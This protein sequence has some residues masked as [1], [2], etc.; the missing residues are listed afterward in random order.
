LGREPSTYRLGKRGRIA[1]SVMQ[2]KPLVSVICLCYNHASYVIEALKSVKAQTYPAIEMIVVDDASTDGSLEIIQEYLKDKQDIPF[3]KLKQNIGNCAAFNQ[4]FQLAQGKYIIDFATDDILVPHRIATQ[5]A[6]FEQLSVQ[7]AVV[8][9]DAALIDEQGAII[10]TYYARTSDGKLKSA[11]PTGEVYQELLKKAFICS[12][13]MMMR[14]AVLA[15]LGGYD[16][17]LSYEDYDFWIRSGR[18]YLY[19]FQDQILTQKRILTD[20]HR[21]SFYK[22]KQNP[23]L[24]STLKI[25]QKAFAQNKSTAENL[26]LAVSV[27]YHL[28]QAL[29]MELFDLALQ[30]AQLL[31]KLDKL[32][33]KDRLS[34]QLAKWRIGLYDLYQWYLQLK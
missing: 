29:F 11:V 14:Q 22:R 30:Y 7:Y 28:R 4:A 31:Q 1:H 13:T 10:R 33:W 12:P 19:H 6:I 23:H 2:S 26:A 15:E 24:V 32:N 25:C 27:R 34:I 21:M 8:F 5:V 9:S 18:K 3:L 20:S 16:E 17:T